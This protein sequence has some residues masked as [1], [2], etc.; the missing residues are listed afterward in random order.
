MRK[1]I[2]QVIITGAGASI[3]YYFPSGNKLFKNITEN[4]YSYANKYYSENVNFINNGK[5]I[6]LPRIKKYIESLQGISGITID[7]YLNINR[8]YLELGIESICAEILRFEKESVNSMN[9]SIDCDWYTYLFSKMLDGLDTIE[10]IENEFDN[11][12][13]II[14][15]NYDRSFENF[16]YNNLY[17]ILCGTELDDNKIKEIVN[18]LPVTHVYGKVGFLPWQKNV[19]SQEIVNFGG[20]SDYF[21]ADAKVIKKHVNVIYQSRMENEQIINAKK[22]I[23]EAD[24]VLF[25]GFG[26]DK[27]NIDVLD[28][29]NLLEKKRV[30]AS[31]YKQ[32]ENEIVHIK[33]TLCPSNKLLTIKDCDCLMLLRDYLIV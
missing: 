30:F 21:Y 9:A 13:S 18:K 26:F 33:K 5:E 11:N 3:P 2:K 4:F 32:T 19:A 14:T 7:K 8:H 16:I 29:P 28:L 15:F 1:K 6:E 10:E 24:R 23:S 27:S 31:A 20:N 22:Q 12:L 25:I 17:K